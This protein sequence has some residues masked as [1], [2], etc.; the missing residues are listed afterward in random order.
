[1]P[2]GPVGS[3]S[4]CAK[5]TLA[6]MGSLLSVGIEG[7]TPVRDAPEQAGGDEA[8]KIQVDDAADP[9]RAV[10][11]Q[12]GDHQ[13]DEGQPLQLKDWEPLQAPSE[14]ALTERI[15][16]IAWLHG[17]SRR[18]CEWQAGPVNPLCRTQDLGCTPQACLAEETRDQSHASV[19]AQICHDASRHEGCRS[20]V[21]DDL[22]RNSPR[23]DEM[24][25]REAC[26]GELC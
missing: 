4:E 5:H 9:K 7:T 19:S 18:N 11:Q 3:E 14:R 6:M 24:S 17:A 26:P 25:C 2:E 21:H 8:D 20:V 22:P 16:G 10:V 1:M 12:P 13:C 23:R 15:H